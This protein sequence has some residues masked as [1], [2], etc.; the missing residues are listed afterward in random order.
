MRQH[1]VKILL[2]GHRNDA[3]HRN[4]SV[5]RCLR[6]VNSFNMFFGIFLLFWGAACQ[7]KTNEP[8]LSDE[9]IARVMADLYI[10]E[11]ATTGLN[12]YPKDSL[13]HVYYDQVLQMHG[14]T[15]EQ[16]EK[17]LRLL[18]LDVSRMEAILEQVQVLLE[19]EKKK[20]PAA[21]TE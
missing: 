20:E 16:Y 14:I 15:K 4:I 5:S 2:P 13:T 3:T 9:K 10:A 19:P 6:V 7:Q 21:P 8:T 18:V 1:T 17:D 11:A 12:G